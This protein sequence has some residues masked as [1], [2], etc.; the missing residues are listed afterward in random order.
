VLKRQSSELAATDSEIFSD[1]FDFSLANGE[2]VYTGDVRAFNP[3]MNLSSG[4]LTIRL[5]KGTNGQPSGGV[6]HILAKDNV[7]IDFLEKPFVNGDITNLVAFAESMKRPTNGVTRFVSS[8]LS[9][10]S[11][12]LLGKY[13]Q[14]KDDALQAALITDLNRVALD[15]TVYQPARFDGIYLSLDTTKLMDQHPL[16]I[17]LVALNRLLLLDAF[18]GQISRDQKGEKTHATGDEATYDSHIVNGVTNQ[19]LVLTGHPRL[20]KAHGWLTAETSIIDDRTTGVIRFIGQPRFFTRL[21][22]LITVP[23]MDAWKKKRE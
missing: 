23:T 18:T 5:N 10:A 13:L 8:Q 14:G 12:N 19:V 22:G 9:T 20:E 7:V 21:D 11:Q 2:S 16:G 4:E 1:T 6:E 3:E 15:G 17:D